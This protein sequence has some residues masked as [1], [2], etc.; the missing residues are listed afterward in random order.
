MAVYARRSVELFENEEIMLAFDDLV[1]GSF[2]MLDAFLSALS[3]NKALQGLEYSTLLIT[4]G[5]YATKYVD[6]RGEPT[7]TAPEAHAISSAYVAH[8]P[9]S[10]KIAT[11]ATTATL[12]RI[13]EVKE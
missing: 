1:M 11:Q 6:A 3:K 9:I 12:D 8:H 5:L 4:I 10:Q 7:T 2:V 13:T